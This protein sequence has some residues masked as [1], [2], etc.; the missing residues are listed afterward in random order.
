MKLLMGEE[1]YNYPFTTF[2]FEVMT[3]Y[4]PSHLNFMDLYVYLCQFSM[5][6]TNKQG[7][8]FKQNWV[9]LNPGSIICWADS[10]TSQNPI[11]SSAQWVK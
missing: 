6:S 3:S 1:S 11:S 8:T 9:K 4:C 2:L 10:V 7:F 5:I